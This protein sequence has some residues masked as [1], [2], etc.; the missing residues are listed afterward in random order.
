VVAIPDAEWGEI[1]R[2]HVVPIENESIE[3][4]ALAGWLETRLARYKQPR[5]IVIE[6]ALPRTASG[7]VQKHLLGNDTTLNPTLN[8][9]RTPSA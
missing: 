8:T 6:S 1:G 7:K 5:E 4:T 9:T 3:P 2:A